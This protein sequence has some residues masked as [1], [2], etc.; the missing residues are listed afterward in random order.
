MDIEVRKATM[1]DIQAITKLSIQL[2]YPSQ[3]DEITA[4]NLEW[5]FGSE[6]DDAFVAD[7][8]GWVIGWMQVTYVV[9]LESK[10]FCELVGLVV[11]ERA[12]G[13]GVGKLLVA[14]AMEWARERGTETLRLRTNVNRKEAHK[15]Y[16]KIGFTLTKEQRVYGM[17]L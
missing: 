5:I 3:T 8:K 11:E 4:T 6:N 15:F 13:G 16:E 1:A 14:R 12:R 7:F 10:P 17:N 2:G 9:R